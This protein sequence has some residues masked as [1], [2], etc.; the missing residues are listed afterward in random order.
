MRKPPIHGKAIG[1]IYWKKGPFESQWWKMYQVP[2]FCA[3]VLVKV[4]IPPPSFWASPKPVG[5]KV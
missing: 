1:E 2:L 4:G 5:K 3:L